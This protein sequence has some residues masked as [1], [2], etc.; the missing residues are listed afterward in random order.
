M[1]KIA[2]LGAAGTIGRVI[3]WDWLR[4]SPE[5]EAILADLHLGPVRALSR[6]LGPRT[7][8]VQVDVSDRP[9]LVALLQKAALVINSTSHHFNLPVMTAA[10]QAGCHYLDLGGLFHFTRR[11]LKMHRIFRTAGKTALL[12]MGCAPGITNL[13][14]RE[15]T[16]GWNEVHAVDIRLAGLDRHPAPDGIPYS[17]RTLIEE[18]T[19]KPA[20]FEEGRW[21]HVEP[22]SGRQWRFFPYPVGKQHLF[23]TLHSEVATLPHFFRGRGIRRVTFRIALNPDLCQRLLDGSVSPAA[24]PPRSPHHPDDEEIAWVEA[25]GI[26]RRQPVQGSMTCQ[27]H[28]DHGWSAGDLNTACPA[29]IAAEL[30][31]SGSLPF[32]S[33][34]AAPEDAVPWLPMAERLNQRGF[35]FSK[36]EHPLDSRQLQ[37]LGV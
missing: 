5:H 35:T 20:V 16:S 10:L 19:C 3:A 37:A 29:S 21:H 2:I 22:Q 25:V 30:L 1:K 14:A 23:Y 12:G 26:R 15:L 6:V 33:G 34:V 4:S 8:A 24:P 13:M 11:Q 7:S 17:A 36:E 27:N 9:R 28:S 32:A 31:L 18:L